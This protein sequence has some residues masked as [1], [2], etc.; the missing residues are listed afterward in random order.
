LNA[1]V[2]A[3]WGEAGV[4]CSTDA[5]DGRLDVRSEQRR[6]PALADIR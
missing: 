6:D 4:M 3:W 2:P 1:L 5:G